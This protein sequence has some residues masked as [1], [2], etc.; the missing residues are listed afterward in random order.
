[1]RS[2]HDQLKCELNI[3]HGA[4]AAQRDETKNPDAEQSPEIKL[5]IVFPGT[6][7]SPGYE[8]ENKVKHPV[9]KLLEEDDENQTEDQVAAA[10]VAELE[11]GR[12]L[13][14]TQRF[15]G[16]AMKA[17]SLM[18]SPRDRPLVDTIFS[19]LMAVVWLFVSWDMERKVWKWGFRNGFPKLSD[20]T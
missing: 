7:L 12:S 5:H 3:Y 1:M 18:G 17:S 13:I 16:A 10:A 2:L 11:K 20:R 9:T 15:Q 8:S 19:W 4:L 6:I 14:T